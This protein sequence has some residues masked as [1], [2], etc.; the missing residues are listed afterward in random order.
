M[1]TFNINYSLIYTKPSDY[2][3][4]SKITWLIKI[5]L[6]PYEIAIFSFQTKI[7]HLVYPLITT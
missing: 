6:S 3:E 5:P 2:F 4:I 7:S 1:S